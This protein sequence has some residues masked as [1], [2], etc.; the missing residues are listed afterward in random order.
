MDFKSERVQSREEWK[1][2]ITK[3][4]TKM[5]LNKRKIDDI[6]LRRQNKF[7]ATLIFLFCAAS[8]VVLLATPPIDGYEI[9]IYTALPLYY[10][11]AIITSLILCIIL[12]IRSSDNVYF[13]L[14]FLGILAN[15][16]ILIFLSFIRGYFLPV[17]GTWDVYH[18]IAQA[19][20]IESEGLIR[21]NRYPIIHIILVAL[22]SIG[23]T[24]ESMTISS[25]L[26]LFHILLLVVSLYAVKVVFK[27][28]E[29][30]KLCFLFFVPFLLGKYHIVLMP[31]QCALVLL[32]LF[33]C[34]LLKTTTANAEEGKRYSIL[35]IIIGMV[36][37]FFHPL[38][39]VMTIIAMVVAILASYISP[40]ILK[41]ECVQ[42]NI[43]IKRTLTHTFFIIFIVYM[44]WL[45]VSGQLSLPVNTIFDF[46]LE[47]SERNLALMNYGKTILVDDNLDLT[48]KISRFIVMYGTLA[49]YFLVGSMGLL[50]ILYKVFEKS[51]TIL[52]INIILLGITALSSGVLLLTGSFVICE[53]ERALG[54]FIILTPILCGIFFS[55]LLLSRKRDHRTILGIMFIAIS[56]TVILGVFD[57]YYS[58]SSTLSHPSP[59]VSYADKS[60]IEFTIIHM[61]KSIPIIRNVNNLRLWPDYI[62]GPNQGYV[63]NLRSTTYLPSRLGYTEHRHFS[64]SYEGNNYLWINERLKQS[65]SGGS[66]NNNIC[67]EED[68]ERLSIDES[69]EK[70]YS[71]N[72]FELWFVSPCIA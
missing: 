13:Y 59:M 26:A 35:L 32:L 45:I 12:I 17:D 3:D 39:F 6:T 69:L 2:L 70:L 31:Y 11:I 7:I 61:D 51:A 16:T 49:I 38:V 4:D 52:D 67:L 43:H 48:Y 15:Y 5:L 36:L 64:E 14:A 30:Q 58:P 28:P 20:F 66:Y 57:L 19:N 8:N 56:F 62:Y 47:D 50:T 54:F 18:H 46:L 25:A 37:V 10:W 27:G 9:S 29:T 72:E 22:K 41:K 44:V 1:Y 60:G 55:N 24:N 68:F 42:P 71:S 40:Y 21:G 34:V 23:I 65:S 33:I 53:I 63:L